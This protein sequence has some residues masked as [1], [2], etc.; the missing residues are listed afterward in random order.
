ML[1]KFFL[2]LG[3]ILL[4]GI[5]YLTL[6]PVP[7]NPVAWDAPKSAG[8]VGKF[9]PNMKLA[10]LKT[11][12]IGDH[13]GPEDIAGRKENG[14]MV[15]YTS[16]QSGDIIRIEPRPNKHSVF[17]NTGGVALGLQ[18]APD[19]NLIIADAH[20]GLL[21]IDANG[22]VSVLTDKVDDG[23]PLVYVDEMAIAADGRIFFSDAS[24]KFGAKAAGSTLKGSLLELMEHGSTGRIVVYN[25]Q[26]KTTKTVVKNLSFPNGVAMCPDDAC[27]IFAET[28]TYSIKR[29]WLTGLQAGI[30]ETIIENLPGF[31]DNINKGQDGRYWV[32]LTSPRAEALD[33]LSGKPFIRKVVQRLPASMRPGAVNYGFIF[34]IDMNGKVLAQYQ[35]PSGAYPL[36]TGATEPGDGWLYIGSL[37]AKELGRKDLRTEKF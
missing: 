26:D 13:H 12:A 7:I 25:P 21:S 1:K 37:G 23:T 8:Y 15:I 28:G 34:A 18:F 16:T 36:T 9:E 22:T 4:L 32:G 27:I 33:N 29:H 3:L 2:S 24:T 17:A 14:E 5:G 6:W 30:T 20:K 11:L 19:G 35:D 10:G 31:P